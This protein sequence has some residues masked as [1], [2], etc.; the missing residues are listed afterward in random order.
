VRVLTGKSDQ[1]RVTSV[2][3]NAQLAGIESVDFKADSGW[4]TVSIDDL[5]AIARAIAL[6]VQACFTAER[7]H[8]EAVAA[9]ATMAEA[10]AYDLAAGW[11]NQ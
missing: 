9:L 2:V 10:R 4:V 11:P 7:A 6:H 5:K 8:H 3:V 1:D